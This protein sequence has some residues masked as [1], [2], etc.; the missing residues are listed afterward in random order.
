MHPEIEALITPV[1]KLN[2]DMTQALKQNGGGIT[3]N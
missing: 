1:F 3:D 2:R